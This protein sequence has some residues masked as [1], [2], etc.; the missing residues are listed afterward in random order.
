MIRK[1]EITAVLNGFVVQVGC[2]A[3]VFE[4]ATK[5]LEEL[6]KYL[7][8]PDATEKSYQT[9]SI[10]SNKLGQVPQAVAER[11][12]ARESRGLAAG[13]VGGLVGAGQAVGRSAFGEAVAEGRLADLRATHETLREMRADPA[14]AGDRCVGEQAAPVDR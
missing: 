12:V 5:M 7:A 11:A 13:L 9:D 8:D 10:N 6:G 14:D 2:T 4:T 3:V 1:I